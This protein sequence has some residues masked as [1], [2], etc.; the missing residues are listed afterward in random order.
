MIIGEYLVFSGVIL[1]ILGVY[2]VFAVLH[3][4]WWA[5]LQYRML[6]K[7]WQ[8]KPLSSSGHYHRDCIALVHSAGFTVACTVVSLGVCVRTPKK[9]AVAACT[10]IHRR[11]SEGDQR[12]NS[13]DAST[14]TRGRARARGCVVTTG[15]LKSCVVLYITT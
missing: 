13:P 15:L 8:H 6:R 1:L 2:S 7:C 9:H 14:F 11:Q 3:S 12:M 4:C 5:T 10:K